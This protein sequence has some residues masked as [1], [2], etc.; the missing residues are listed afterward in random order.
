MSA[1]SWTDSVTGDGV[2][3][4]V[5]SCLGR[6]CW[7]NMVWA[8]VIDWGTR[9]AVMGQNL[10]NIWRNLIGFGS[11]DSQVEVGGGARGVLLGRKSCCCCC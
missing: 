8:V 7:G 3:F 10:V 11:V 9:G 6:D 5:G 2:G 4:V 1:S